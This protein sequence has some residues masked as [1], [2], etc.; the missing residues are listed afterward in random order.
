MSWNTIIKYLNTNERFVYKNSLCMSY[1]DSSVSTQEK[2]K[3][4]NENCYVT[5]VSEFNNSNV[6]YSSGILWW[7]RSIILNHVDEFHTVYMY[8]SDKS[9]NVYIKTEY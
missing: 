3:W 9:I 1:S 6:I 7:K 2:E 5:S 8:K 4:I